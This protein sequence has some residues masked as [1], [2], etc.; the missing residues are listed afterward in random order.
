MSIELID[1]DPLTGVKTYLEFDEVN[2]R[3]FHIHKR[4]D[5]QPIL[6]AN[7]LLQNDPE[8][9][10]NGIKHGMQHIARIPEI[11]VHYFMKKYGLDIM[12]REARPKLHKLLQDPAYKFLRTTL[13]RI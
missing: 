3:K 5:V 9:K 13:G 4:Q 11:W 1:D 7:K 2:P 6:E 12:R 8:Y 10:K